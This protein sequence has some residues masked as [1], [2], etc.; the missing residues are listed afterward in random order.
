M[1]KIMIG[2]IVVMFAFTFAKIINA[3]EFS[4]AFPKTVSEI[5]DGADAAALGGATVAVPDFSS[6]NP[7]VIA[8]PP[9][10]EK[11]P[12]FGV[13][14]NYGF[15]KFKN[16]PDVNLGFISGTAKLPVGVLQIMGSYAASDTGKMD[17]FNNIKIN[18]SPYVGFQYGLSIVKDLYFGISYTYSE[19]EI[20]MQ[21]SIENPLDLEIISKSKGHEVGAGM[22]YQLLKNKV[23]LGLF[24]AHSW[25]EEKTF[26]DGSLDNAE[27]SQTD[28]V[29]FGVSAKI[30]SMTM[31]SAEVRHY[32]FPNGVTDT[33]FFAGI[34]Q[35][36]IK[37]SLAL[38][39]GYANGGATAGLGV[40]FKN[41]GLNLAYMY[42]PFRATEEFLG[43]AEAIMLSVYVSF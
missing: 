17:E 13:Y 19:S 42:R 14:A 32:W 7:S 36:L 15:I 16:G 39:G 1:K 8:V 38:Y 3:E 21:T 6:K 2:M 20:T 26:I 11:T 35:Y 37:D 25:D 28:Q 22:L 34:E 24:Y 41:G 4:T 23:N 30:T 33:Q 10:G 31:I 5:P 40:Y 9:V 18:S 29:R 27:K 43:K 12:D